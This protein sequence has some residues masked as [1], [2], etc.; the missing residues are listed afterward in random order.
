MVDSLYTSANGIR[1][2][3][4]VSG[5]GEDTILFIHGNGS[6]SV[7]WKALMSKFPAKYRTLAP[8]LRGFGKTEAVPCDA[9][10]SFGSF[11]EDLSALLSELGVAKYHLVGH[12]LGG[13]IGWEL[14]IK[15]CERIKSVTLINPASPFGFG[16]SKDEK[17]TPNFEDGAGSG[18]GLINP[19]FVRLLKAKDKTNGEQAS[20]LQIMNTYYW[21]PPFVPPNVDE[22]LDGL[23]RMRLG[24]TY[25]PGDSEPSPNFP[26]SAP[27]NYGQ[28]NAAAPHSKKGILEK[29]TGLKKKP[30][31]L[32]IRG[33][34]DQIVSDNS[35]FD[36][37]VQGLDGAKAGWPGI[38][39]CPPQPMVRQSRFVLN[40]YQNSGGKFQEIVMANCGHSPY[41]EDSNAFNAIFLPWIDRNG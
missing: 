7:F 33:A 28:N 40:A 16:G 10:K 31:I 11:V 20:P 4:L 26:F 13:G 21:S 32:W 15:D 24:D 3:L 41:I 6:D 17:G 1:Q 19:D 29:L 35:H 34:K 36:A 12:S 9:K 27:G 18:A 30:P 25:Y 14:L 2:H 8:D 5:R 23:L 37:A 39:V 38:E 22:L